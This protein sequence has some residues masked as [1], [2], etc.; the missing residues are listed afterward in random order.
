MED[1]RTR[2]GADIA[3]GHHLVVAKMKLELKNYWTTGE[4]ALQRFNTASLRD[5]SKINQ[6]KIALNNRYQAL[7]DLLKGEE[8]TMEDNWKGVK[9]APIPRRNIKQL[10][11]AIK[12]RS[13]K[14]DKP[15][16]K[17]KDK[18]GKTITEIREQK[19]R[20]V[21]H[22]GE[23]LNR[24]APLS[25]PDIEAATTDLPICVTTPMIKVIGMAITQ[26]KS[27]KAEGSGNIP[28]EAVKYSKVRFPSRYILS[29][30]TLKLQ[31]KYLLMKEINDHLIVGKLVQAESII[32]LNI[33]QSNQWKRAQQSN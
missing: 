29:T 24:P 11:D 3:S 9:E 32:I 6:V 7:Q 33:D 8:N 28:A 19:Y 31:P 4:T 12:K 22:F 30:K 2:R 23:L 1:V 25:P 14:Y 20:R 5:A 16:G 13:A 17:I 21:E 10:Y 18:E 27:E 15:D 26:M